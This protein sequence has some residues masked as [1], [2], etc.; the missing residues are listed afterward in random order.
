MLAA[1]LQQLWAKSLPEVLP[2]AFT[3]KPGL[4]D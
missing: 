2:S 1:S 3:L 4:S